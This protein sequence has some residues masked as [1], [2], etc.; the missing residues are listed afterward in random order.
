[1][2]KHF[3]LSLLAALLAG[4]FIGTNAIAQD[5]VAPSNGLSPAACA[6]TPTPRVKEYEWMSI[7]KWNEIHAAQ[8][9]VAK[10]GGIDL[11][12][13]GDSITQGWPHDFFEQQFGRFHAAN[14]GVGGDPTGHVP[15]RLDDPV[16]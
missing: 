10:Q 12:F 11:M 9:A 5:A 4:Q 8:Q 15:Y 6:V 7:A 13:V 14:F 1:M 16:T 2:H 3:T